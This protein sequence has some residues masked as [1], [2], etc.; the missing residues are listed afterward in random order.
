MPPVDAMPTD[1]TGSFMGGMPPLSLTGGDA[2]SRS[3]S[4]AS[5]SVGVTFG[6]P[7][8][9]GGSGAGVR[10]DQATS[11]VGVMV[12]IGMVIGGLAWLLTRRK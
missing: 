12:V 2:M 10:Q 5:Q 8:V 4:N 11:N 9:F 7:F 6:S 1:P 3:R